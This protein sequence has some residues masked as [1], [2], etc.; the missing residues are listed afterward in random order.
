MNRYRIVL[1]VLALLGAV[2]TFLPWANLPLVGSAD[3]TSGDGPGWITLGLFVVS[4]VVAVSTRRR[5]PVS[6]LVAAAC[7]APALIAGAYAVYKML[8]LQSSFAGVAATNAI[9]K[10]ILGSVTAG[11][12]LYVVIAVA[13]VLPVAAGIFSALPRPL[14]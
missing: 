5:E 6:R 10:A 11:V 14:R 2:G 1:V 13:V 3:G 4:G 7:G 8:D 9:A 12:G